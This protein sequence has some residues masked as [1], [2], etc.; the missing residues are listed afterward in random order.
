MPTRLDLA[1][2]VAVVTGAAGGIGRAVALELA[3]RGAALALADRDTEGLAE[4]VRRAQLLGP[5]VTAHA[6]DVT[7]GAA[8]GGFRDA[9]LAAHGRVSVLVNNAGAGLAGRFEETSEEEFRWQMEVNLFSVVALTRA[10]LPALR[11][12]PAAQLVNVS[13]L[14]GLIGPAEQVAYATSKF[15]VRG[16]SEA[17]RHE[18]G[19]T[20][21]GVTVVHP[22]GV[23]TRIAAAARVAA[24]ADRA[25]VA[26]MQA[27]FSQRAL[28]MPPAAAAR[29]IVRGIARRER[30]VL[31]GADARLADLVQ[32]LAPG[33]YW[34]AM[35]PV[36]AR[37]TR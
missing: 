13:S 20:G 22:G 2:A 31:V 5:V 24:G 30:R 34:A 27:A 4:T 18:L 10:F 6:L 37:I 25:R 17:L 19:G 1:R 26:A 16:F 32:R 36:F 7:E 23:R 28:R 8:T 12:E 35:R 14:F 21:V 33:A 9:V 29:R 3:A 15:A 11:A